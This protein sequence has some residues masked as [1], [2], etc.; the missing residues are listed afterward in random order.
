MEGR[1][2]DAGVFLGVDAN[3]VLH[4]EEEEYEKTDEEDVFLIPLFIRSM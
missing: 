3:S 2:W 1:C 4:K